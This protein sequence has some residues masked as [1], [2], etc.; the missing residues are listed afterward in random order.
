[1]T[2]HSRF[3]ENRA[4]SRAP[5][6]LSGTSGLDAAVTAPCDGLKG[7]AAGQ[8]IA[9]MTVPPTVTPSCRRTSRATVV[10]V[11][12]HFVVSGLI[13]RL[14][15]WSSADG[16][17][18]AAGSAGQSRGRGRGARRA[19]LPR[20]PRARSSRRPAAI[21]RWVAACSA[22]LR[23]AS[24]ARSSGGPVSVRCSTLSAARS[25]GLRSCRRQRAIARR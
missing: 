5:W 9:A 25:S 1:M 15:V 3:H 23:R 16:A 11:G 10:G 6:E 17:C 22:G 19:V 7:L 24:R 20:G 13:C 18:G 2:A 12:G 21:I 14:R 4:A 8:I